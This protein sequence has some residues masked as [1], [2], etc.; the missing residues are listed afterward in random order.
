MFSVDF[1]LSVRPGQD[2]RFNLHAMPLRVMRG[3]AQYMDKRNCDVMAVYVLAPTE[4]WP[5]SWRRSCLVD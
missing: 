5:R 2:I 4:I 3:V 1:N